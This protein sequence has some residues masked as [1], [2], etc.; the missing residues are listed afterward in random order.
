LAAHQLAEQDG[1]R[2]PGEH[3]VTPLVGRDPAGREPV[4]AVDDPVDPRVSQLS[5][6][7]GTM[8]VPM[9]LAA[10]VTTRSAPTPAAMSRP[11]A[12]TTMALL[13]HGPNLSLAGSLHDGV[14][15]G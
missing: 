15:G 7:R 12:G 1:R 13:G 4:R 2:L 9:T 14:P 5:T 11:K 3:P 8:I 10:A 6:G